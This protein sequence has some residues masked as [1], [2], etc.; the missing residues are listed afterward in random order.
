MALEV[1]PYPPLGWLG[2][3][4]TL[5]GSKGAQ[6]WVAK[7]NQIAVFTT[8]FG[9]GTYLWRK[10]LNFFQKKMSPKW[11]GMTCDEPMMS[12]RSLVAVPLAQMITL[13][14]LHFPQSLRL[15]Y[16]PVV[17][18]VKLFPKFFFLP[19]GSGGLAMNPR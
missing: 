7:K 4:G 8:V 18:S 15:R 6:T 1:L 9:K 10:Q 11:L 3:C 12:S 19:N 5:G 2:H 13:K 17:K 14:I 16:P